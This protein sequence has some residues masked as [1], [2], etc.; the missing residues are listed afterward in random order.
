MWTVRIVKRV[1][2]SGWELVCTFCWG[3]RS[4][5]ERMRNLR[6]RYISILA[7]SHS[8]E[9]SAEYR[10]WIVH[11]GWW[12]TNHVF[13]LSSEFLGG[14]GHPSVFFPFF[15]PPPDAVHSVLPDASSFFSLFS[16]LVAWRV[17]EIP[18][19][20][21]VDLLFLWTDVGRTSLNLSTDDCS[22]RWLSGGFV[23]CGGGFAP[24]PH[25]A[26]HV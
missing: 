6:D 5:S 17:M 26:L 1:A 3:M 9:K 7:V 12:A 10:R 25:V 24:P 2:R 22:L 15:L 11:R 14:L 18:F 8:L 19:R 13:Q 4:G 23:A 16:Y 21:L 20:H